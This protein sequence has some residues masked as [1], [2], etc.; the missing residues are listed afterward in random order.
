MSN[1]LIVSAGQNSQRRFFD[2]P[3]EPTWANVGEKIGSAK[4]KA[5]M[6]EKSGMAWD[7]THRP[8][9]VE[10]PD[11]T[12]QRVDDR[13]AVTRETDGAYLGVVG[14]RHEIVQ[15]S[16]LFDIAEMLSNEHGVE[17]VR[18]GIYKECR[19]QWLL[20]EQKDTVKVGVEEGNK[21]LLIANAVDGSRSLGI[22]P[23]MVMPFCGNQISAIERSDGATRFRHTRSVRDRIE[24]VATMYKSSE[25]GF[26]RMGKVFNELANRKTTEAQVKKFLRAVAKRGSE[27]SQEAQFNIL[28]E[29]YKN[30][31][32]Q[33]KRT[34]SAWK[35]LC[36]VTDTVDHVVRPSHIERASRQ[37]N[38]RQMFSATFGAG[39]NLKRRALTIAQSMFLK[40]S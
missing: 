35:A 25:M 19:V 30:G 15:P 20:A 28:M 36:A 34:N 2:L 4:S 14:R 38:E 32:G 22:T 23:T 16:E 9:H 29:R 11:G 21:Y 18:A 39:A 33:D 26:Q 5:E 40:A 17:F 6:M 3:P 8:I 13:V 10:Q 27:K 31:P 12:M 1:E 37:K 24:A 7:V